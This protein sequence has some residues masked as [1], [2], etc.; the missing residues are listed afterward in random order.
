RRRTWR[1]RAR[2]SYCSTAFAICRTSTPTSRPVRCPRE[3]RRL[4]RL[5]GDLLDTAR[6]EAGGVQLNV[7]EISTAELFRQ[8]ATRHERECR[9]REITFETS[10]L[11]DAETFEADPF[12]IEHAIENVVSNALRH[13][14]NNGRIAVTAQRCGE[15]IVIEVCDSGEGIPAEHLPH[16]FDRFY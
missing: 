11:P 16:I 9:T 5:I 2:T 6:H 4:R 1:R 15:N 3:A 13:T 8:V 12:R 7:E 14:P 10:F